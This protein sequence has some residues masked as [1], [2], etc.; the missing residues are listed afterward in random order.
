MSKYVNQC[1]TNILTYSLINSSKREADQ[2]ILAE[3]LQE[4]T[5][6]KNP[7]EAKDEIAQRVY[8][9]VNEAGQPKKLTTHRSIY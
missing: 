5:Q 3:P 6:I 9:L 4:A 1:R 2:P 7:A 8:F